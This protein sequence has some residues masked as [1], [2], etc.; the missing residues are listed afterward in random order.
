MKVLREIWDAITTP[1][2]ALAV[3]IEESKNINEDGSW[4]SYWQKRN[5]RNNRK[6]WG[7]L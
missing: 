1:F 3:N 5:E 7:K 2:I 6:K 4:D